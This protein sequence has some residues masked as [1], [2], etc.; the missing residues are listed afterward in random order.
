MEKLK[1]IFI[2]PV[3]VCCFLK[4]QA[5]PVTCIA[6]FSYSFGQAEGTGVNVDF[7]STSQS[8]AAITSYDWN[9]GD[10]ASYGSNPNTSSL[11]NPVHLYSHFGSYNV[12]LTIHAA[13][14]CLNTICQTISIPVIDPGPCYGL[15]AIWTDKV[16][17]DAT[18]KFSGT[19]DSRNSA[20]YNWNFGDGTTGKGL[21]ISHTYASSGTYDVCLV[22]KIK[23]D[24]E[25]SF[26]SCADVAVTG[27]CNLDVTWT[28]SQ[29]GAEAL[30]V[31]DATSPVM[32]VTYTWNFGDGTTATGNPVSHK[33]AANGF[34]QVCL[35][36]ICHM[37]D[38]GGGPVCVDSSLINNSVACPTYD[39]PVCGCNGVTYPN[40]CIAE[41]Y[42]GVTSWTNGACPVSPGTSAGLNSPGGISS[43]PVSNKFSMNIYPN[44]ASNNT[45]V[46]YNLPTSAS[47]NIE[48]LDMLGN[49]VTSV[50]SG[51][52]D[53][54]TQ[55]AS[56]NT[57]N[58]S[59]GIYLV[60]MAVDGKLYTQ[61]LS[62]IH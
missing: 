13:N 12:C 58:M 34:Y 57:R 38:V 44:P 45:T 54:G 14:E 40:S 28:A 32:G 43:A 53:A 5:Q 20:V 48:V 61:R 7:T 35:A 51:N 10:T 62:V 46:L 1:L 36:N 29:S 49:V 59:T 50:Y 24:K 8:G 39:E 31:F 37:V 56:W 60:R 55:S 25:C 30:V 33:Y 21:H 9:F 42:G 15:S 11:P 27:L 16:K 3:I 17:S 4:I 41:Y 47:V 6:G 22:A 19:P 23:D 52:Q 18:V 26:T 2:L